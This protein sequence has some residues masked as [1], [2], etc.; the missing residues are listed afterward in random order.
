[1]LFK[2]NVAIYAALILAA[3]VLALGALT[4]WHARLITRGESSVE[5]HIND[6]ERKRLSKQGH[7]YVNPYNFGPKKNWRLFLGLVRGR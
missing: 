4:C 2:R 7:T 5:A 1:M 3:V 6:S